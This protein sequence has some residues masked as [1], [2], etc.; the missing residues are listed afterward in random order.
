MKSSIA[1]VLALS[2]LASHAALTIPLPGNQE[3][4]T[5]SDLS[6]ATYPGYGS[7]G[8]ST[9]NWPGSL[10]ANLGTTSSVI[11]KVDGT[12]GYVSSSNYIYDGG[13]PGGTFILSDANPISGL[14]TIVFQ[15]EANQAPDSISLSY[16]G[17]TQALAADFTTSGTGDDYMLFA[18]QWDLS[19]E[20][21]ISDYSITWVN[22]A[23]HTLTKRFDLD[24][25]D[26]FAQAIPEPSVAILIS[27][28]SLSLFRRRR[29]H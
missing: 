19:G 9:A 2:S 23:P 28:L 14:Q 8:D 17:G 7:H 5:W 13:V 29:A 12:S 24:S 22:P 26:Q 16:N 25:S 27:T 6:A 21:A 1:I 10:S 20:G 3:S 18:Y 4:A 11:D 15:I